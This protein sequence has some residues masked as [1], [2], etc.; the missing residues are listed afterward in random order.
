MIPHPAPCPPLHLTSCN[1]PEHTA[2]I[3]GSSLPPPI[4]VA[5]TDTRNSPTYNLCIQTMPTLC[6]LRRGPAIVEGSRFVRRWSSPSVIPE[7]NHEWWTCWHSIRGAW[8]GGSWSLFPRPIKMFFHHS[9]LFDWNL[10]MMNDRRRSQS[11][12]RLLDP[13]CVGQFAPNPS[14]FA[15]G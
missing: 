9:P 10:L 5:D 1:L 15:A 13:E 7:Q 3:V 14:C 8:Q 11:S 2:A 12:R 4:A 6:L